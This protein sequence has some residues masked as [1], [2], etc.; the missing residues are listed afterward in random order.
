M[1][2]EEI[3]ALRT[4]PL[5]VV[6]TSPTEGTVVPAGPR[7][8][9]VR[10]LVLPEANIT[11]NGKPI[12]NVRSSGY[13]LQAQFLPNDQTTVTVTVEREGKTRT[14]RRTF[15]FVRRFF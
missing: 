1:I 13:F 10:G 7:H 3:E 5:L 2:A 8:V 12:I 6:Q 4:S 15:K 11:V 14:T 9:I